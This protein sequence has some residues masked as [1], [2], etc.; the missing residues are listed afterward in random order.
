MGEQTEP[1]LESS[2]RECHSAVVSV[3]IP[4]FNSERYLEDCLASLE[5]QTHG[6]IEIIIAD[7]GSTDLTK[8]IAARHHAIFLVL[9]AD[10]RSAQLN[11]AITRS[12]G[13][14][15]Y[16][17]D[18]DFV[19]DPD[20][21]R[22]AV[23]MCELKAC[24]VIAVHNSSDP[25]AS[26]WARVRKLERDC[27]RDDNLNIAARFFRRESLL[28]VGGF[29]ESMIAC[30]D[31][32]LH[33]RL[34]IAGYSVGKIEAE[35][36]HLGEPRTIGE[37]V[38]KHYYYGRSLKVFAEKNRGRGTKQLLPFRKSYVRHV[39][40]FARQPILTLVFIIYQT[41]RYSAAIAGYTAS[42]ISH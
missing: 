34:L 2:T 27:Y 10:E 15:I 16:R 8:Q 7:R 39:N 28:A 25:S 36:R 32:D 19:L 5:T 18:S 3:I 38:R 23:E 17:V 42:A 1:A 13:S 6:A 31:Y 40:D 14:Y 29:D 35:E 30:E 22:Q 41:L 11:Q 9:N 20:V 4:T 12:T 26:I 33:N 24:D 37:V 21:I